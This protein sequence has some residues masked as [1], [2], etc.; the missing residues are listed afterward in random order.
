MPICNICCRPLGTD[1]YSGELY[2]RVARRVVG[3]LLFVVFLC[4]L[5]RRGSNCLVRLT[6][7]ALTLC[8]CLSAM[9]AQEVR[10]QAM[11]HHVRQEVTES[12]AALMGR[13]ADDTQMHLSV[14]LPLRNQAALN[15]L[16]QRLYDRSSPDYH[17]FLTVAQFT[18]Q[19]GPTEDDYAAVATYLRSHGLKVEAAPANRLIVPLSGS[20]AQVNAAFNL[21]L[22]TY[23]HPTENR[24]FFS[25][26]REPSMRLNVPVWHIAG[27]DNF[28]KPRHFMH[29]KM[30]GEAA[31]LAMN[32]S[33]PGTSYLGSDMRAAYYGGTTLDGTGQ[34]VGLLEFGGYDM[35]DVTLT[36][37]NAG[38]TT[39]VPINNVLLD[40]ATGGP[41]GPY[42]DGEQ[43]L[44]IVQAIGMAP[45]LSQVRVYIG[46]GL[47]DA[48][49]LNSMASEN[50]AKQ[51]SCS[52][53][54]LPADPAADDV[55]FEEMAAQGQSFFAASGDDGAFDAAISPFFYPA[56]DQYVTTVG[57][58][59][60]TTSGPRRGLGLRDGMELGRCWQRRWY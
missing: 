9:R 59:H 57:G 56:E 20:A 4:R 41:E 40:G 16:L 10:P 55:F 13:L 52:W 14:I 29:R 32:G 8:T 36:F 39:N 53:G 3:L 27:L 1:G 22:K 21:Q 24:T 34:A 47:D 42:G 17:H 25:P 50:I 5:Y 49:I 51:L 58:T 54:W 26:D 2:V 45:G 28:S 37:S 23:Q 48:H 46:S 43:V 11:H 12:R 30:A 18:E 38:Q 7:L 33:G 19:F 35:T 15:G 60:L 44:D 6:A 31:P